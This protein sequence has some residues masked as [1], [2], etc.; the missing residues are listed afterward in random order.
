MK[1][2]QELCVVSIPQAVSTVATQWWNNTFNYFSVSIPQ[3]VSTVATLHME[4]HPS[5]TDE[6]SIPQAVSTVA[7]QLFFHNERYV[8]LSWVSFNTAS[9]KYCCNLIR[10]IKAEEVSAG[11]NTASGKYC[12]NS[13]QFL[14]KELIAGFNTASGK[15]CC[16]GRRWNVKQTLSL[17]FQYRKR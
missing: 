2:I 12:C 1:T 7:T 14:L 9:G 16:N 15:Y 13:N 10:E 8:E 6:V 4:T 5:K 3:A 17:K 11:F